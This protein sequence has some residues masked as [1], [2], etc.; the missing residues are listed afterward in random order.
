M[1]SIP[2]TLVLCFV[3]G[4]SSAGEGSPAAH[5]QGV[6]SAHFDENRLCT[7]SWQ[8]IVDDWIKS[9][10]SLTADI[11]ANRTMIAADRVSVFASL[12]RE[13]WRRQVAAGSN[14]DRS[15]AFNE[16]LESRNI[17]PDSCTPLFWVQSVLAG[18]PAAFAPGAMASLQKMLGID[19][20]RLR[21]TDWMMSQ[22]LISPANALN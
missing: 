8:N 12:I 13:V 20:D 18:T 14:A 7:A 11:E 5:S 1:R 21:A 4:C 16:V 22:L 10:G 9:G 19:D 17:V 3:A 15:F 2:C 6:L